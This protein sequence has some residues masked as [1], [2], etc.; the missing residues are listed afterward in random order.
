MMG[1]LTCSCGGYIHFDL[2]SYFANGDYSGVC[3]SCGE[4]HREA[5]GVV[6]AAVWNYKGE[7]IE[8]G[9]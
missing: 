8:G 5:S 9:E 1:V 7:D 3:E 2:N 6:D 4:N